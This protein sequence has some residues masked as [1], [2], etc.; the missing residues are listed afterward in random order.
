MALIGIYIGIACRRLEI[1]PVGYKQN[2]FITLI[3]VCMKIKNK[4]HLKLIP[5]GWHAKVSHL[6]MGHQCQSNAIGKTPEEAL[7]NLDE[8]L[9]K[10]QG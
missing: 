8:F 6:F 7:K 3:G 5:E 1:S 2:Q 4:P 9:I 10:Q